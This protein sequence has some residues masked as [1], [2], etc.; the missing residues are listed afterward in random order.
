ML[1]RELIEGFQRL[2]AGDFSYRLPPKSAGDEAETR[3]NS[4]DN[5]QRFQ[6]GVADFGDVRAQHLDLTEYSIRPLTG[7]AWACVRRHGGD[8]RRTCGCS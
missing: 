3:R 2:V 4:G 1:S 6:V 8:A 5:I 7:I